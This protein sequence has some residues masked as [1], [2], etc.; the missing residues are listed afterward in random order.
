MIQ[1]VSWGEKSY[2]YELF[3]VLDAEENGSN[4]LIGCVSNIGDG[5]HSSAGENMHGDN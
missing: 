1:G 3:R 5:F 4:N 2:A